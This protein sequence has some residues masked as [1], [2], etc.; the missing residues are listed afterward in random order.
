MIPPDR[1][2]LYEKGGFG[3]NTVSNIARP[4]S[5]TY[6]LFLFILFGNPLK[7]STTSPNLDQL[8]PLQWSSKLSEFHPVSYNCTEWTKPTT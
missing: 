1:T 4:K 8:I 7:N 3:G 5:R 2:A 6:N